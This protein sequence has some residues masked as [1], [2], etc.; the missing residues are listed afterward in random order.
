MESEA[1]FTTRSEKDSR[2][3]VVHLLNAEQVIGT[4]LKTI[5][6]ISNSPIQPD[7]SQN[8]FKI[9]EYEAD[10]PAPPHPS[11]E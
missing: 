9:G 1:E 8:C 2:L 7:I 4:M 6:H 5:L 10:H 3:G 11:V